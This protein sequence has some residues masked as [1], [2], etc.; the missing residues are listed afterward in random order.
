[1]KRSILMSLVVIGAVVALLAGGATFAP[2]TDSDSDKGEVTA[3]NVEIE[4]LGTGTLT[5]DA[6]VVS[7]PSPMAPG[8]TC[9]AS[10]QV[11]NT[12]D[13][14]VTL[15]DPSHSITNVSG[16]EGTCDAGD[17]TTATANLSYTPDVTNVAPGGVKTFNAKVTLDSDAQEG[18]QGA[19]AEVT[20]EVTA[21]SS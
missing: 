16:G 17:W 3:G 5:F 9:T 19:T 8:D 1:M 7:C 10:V 14:T 20:V 4:V 18:C 12:G 13:L 21:T 15:S 11:Q 2:F 6:P